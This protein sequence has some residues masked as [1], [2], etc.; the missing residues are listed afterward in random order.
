LSPYLETQ[1]TPADRVARRLI[2]TPSMHSHRDDPQWWSLPVGHI[3]RIKAQKTAARWA[4][5]RTL[6]GRTVK[7]SAVAFPIRDSDKNL[8]GVAISYDPADQPA[9]EPHEP[10]ADHPT[11][12]TG[13]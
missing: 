11:F 8:W 7:F 5:A 4:R 1:E 12:D 6:D 13:H 10:T 2:A 9:T 3:G